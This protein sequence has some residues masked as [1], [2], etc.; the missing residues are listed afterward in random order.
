MLHQQFLTHT[1]HRPTGT[2]YYDLTHSWRPRV[3]F[4]AEEKFLFV[5]RMPDS[6][7][8]TVPQ[9]TV[10]QA[11]DGSSWQAGMAEIQESYYSHTP[12]TSGGD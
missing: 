1:P 5:F 8:L 4:P 6:F 3:T 12:K 10:Q 2:H 7:Q 11:G 9:L